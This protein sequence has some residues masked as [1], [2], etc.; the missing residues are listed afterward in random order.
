[1][2]VVEAGLESRFLSTLGAG[3]VSSIGQCTVPSSPDPVPIL[4]GPSIAGQA[5][6][7]IFAAAQEFRGAQTLSDALKGDLSSLASALGVAGDLDDIPITDVVSGPSLSEEVLGAISGVRKSKSQSTA[8]QLTIEHRI[9]ASP[10]KSLADI[11][12]E[13]YLSRGRIGQLEETIRSTLESTVGDRLRGIA[14]LIREQ[15]EPVIPETEFEERIRSTFSLD[16]TSDASDTDLAIARQLLRDALEY[17]CEA[18]VCI[19][20]E[21]SAILDNLRS[22]A[23]KLADDAGLVDEHGLQAYLP[24][25]AWLPHWEVL[26]DRIPLHRLSGRLARPA[27]A[28]AK[29]AT[30]KAKAKAALLQIGKPATK[31]EIA[32]IAELTLDQV[33]AQMYALPSIVRADKI[34]WGLAEWVD[35][36]F[37]GI[38]GEIIQRINEDGGTT[39]IERLLE[40]LPRMFGVSAAS[41][42]A[43][44]A[45]PAF[46]V[47]Q[48]WV[49]LRREHEKYHYQN[50]NVRDASGVFALGD[51]IVALLYKIDREVMRGSGRQLS[52]AAAAILDLSIDER[53]LF[54]GPIG[55]SVTATFLSTSL[56]GPSL[57]S[58]RAL[59]KAVNAKVEDMLTVILRRGDMTVSAQ[60]TDLNEHGTGWALVARLT[61]INE[62]AG[63]DGLAAA[64]NCGR[65]EVRA[66]L[67]ARGDVAVLEALPE[68]GLTPDLEAA[69][70]ALDAEMQREE[71]L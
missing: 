69:L 71:P 64:L 65:G 4:G 54:E 41:V 61:G 27:T 50:S 48:G 39:Q 8:A 44:V 31:E 58:T 21:A 47:E 60:A 36:E 16:S 46:H 57:G 26:I 38:A 40:E 5:L 19:N 15:L 52:P 10:P 6:E 7:R 20:A 11:G 45:T 56:S 34:R 49:R 2:C 62:N 13:V 42:R 43:S 33:R 67:R 30:V 14:A 25:D 12:R 35:D 32:E 9:I 1:M 17:S 53:L 23:T 24:N 18:G 59:A 55:T 22:T 51:G 37:E 68:Q 66:T 28:K 63:M 70:A 29:A 3:S